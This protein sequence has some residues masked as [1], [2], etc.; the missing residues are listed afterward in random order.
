MAGYAV[1]RQKASE[2]GRKFRLAVAKGEDHES[3]KAVKEACDLNLGLPLFSGNKDIIRREAEKAGITEYEILPAETDQQA[4]A[5]AVRAVVEERA[6]LLMKGLVSTSTL[7]KEVL[8]EKGG[9]LRGN[10]LSH[11][12]VVEK[13]DG[14]FVGVTD[15][16]M[17]IAPD[18]EQKAAIIENSVRFF[19]SLGVN[20]PKVA[21][22]SAIEM[23]NRDMS[24]TVDAAVLT[25]MG[26]RG[27]FGDCV[28]EGP[29]SLDLSVN[30]EACEIKGLKGSEINGNA[31]ILLVPEIV[32]GNILGKSL[33]LFAGLQSGG[34][35]TGASCPILL[36]S[37]AD[38][39][40]E[41]LNAILLGIIRIINGV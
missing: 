34:L 37:R 16:G 3:F 26:Q 15:G 40:R 10:L 24:S 11:L 30:P 8:K 33:V 14:T 35:I 31:D 39:A 2:A 12:L 1:L 18:L 32:G 23:V 25:K 28:V 21:V 13:K 7:L 5:E 41:K 38:S 22:L 27:R 4:A 36:M 6:D 19:R 20:R 17:N 29:L 9:L